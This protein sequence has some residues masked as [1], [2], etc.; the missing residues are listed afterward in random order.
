[1][2]LSVPGYIKDALR[3][4][5]HPTPIRMLHIIGMYPIMDNAS[6]V[7]HSLTLTPPETSQDIARVQAI[8]GTLL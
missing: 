8:V 1:M 5:Q 3:K 2:D 7:P 4:F 6:D